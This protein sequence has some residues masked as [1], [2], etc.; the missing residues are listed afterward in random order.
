MIEWIQSLEGLM[1]LSFAG[2]S[3]ASIILGVI[4]VLKTF[5]SG[6]NLKTIIQAFDT[7]KVE[8]KKLEEE[9]KILE[10]EKLIIEAENSLERKQNA[11]MNAFTMKAMSLI[12]AN[13][14]GISGTDKIALIEESKKIQ[15]N[16]FEEGKKQL[17]S[18]KGNA[19]KAKEILEDVKK[20]KD[21]IVNTAEETFEEAKNLLEKYSKKKV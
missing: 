19:K 5:K 15:E 10:E 8:I 16:V 6:F 17:E 3:V 9:K 11:E 21:E 4:A 20:S 18:L 13:A 1:T 14:S 12:I 2:V 7:A